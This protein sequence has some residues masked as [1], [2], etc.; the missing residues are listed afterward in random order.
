MK[1]LA[2]MIMAAMLLFSCQKQQELKSS[3]I[4]GEWH[5]HSEYE[6]GS[7]AD[8]YVAFENGGSFRLYQLIGEG[9]YTCYSGTWSYEGGLLKGSYEDGCAWASS[10]KVELLQDVL[11]LS[12]SLH[13]EEEYLYL[14]CTIP[15]L[16]I[17]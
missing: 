11:L 5:H 7:V 3:D 10:Y 12:C 16:A 17:Y 13:P 9:R 4:V 8:V 14:S 15:E 1:K 6:D 2:F